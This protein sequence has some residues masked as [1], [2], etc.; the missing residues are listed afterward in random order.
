[1]KDKFRMAFTMFCKDATHPTVYHKKVGSLVLV[2]LYNPLRLRQNG[3]HFA[4]D[5]F[6]V[7]FLYENCYILIQISLKCVAKG[8]VNKNWAL[9]QIMAWHQ[10]GLLCW[11][12]LS[13]DE[14]QVLSGFMWCIYPCIRFALN[15]LKWGPA[16]IWDALKR[17]HQRYH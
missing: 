6:N 15:N 5:I 3:C 11:H 14:N 17:N 13:L 4:D 16:T 8:L 9:V 10:T 7:V 12:L 1:M 2:C